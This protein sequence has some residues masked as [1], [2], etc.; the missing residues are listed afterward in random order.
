MANK[1]VKTEKNYKLFFLRGQWRFASTIAWGNISQIFAGI[2][3]HFAQNAHA[4][5]DTLEDLILH[6]RPAIIKW[7]CLS[8]KTRKHRHWEHQYVPCQKSYIPLIEWSCHRCGCP[9]PPILVFSNFHPCKPN[10]T[11]RSRTRKYYKFSW[12]P[13][14]VSQSQ[15]SGSL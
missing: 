11:A 10:Q 1:K 4:W 14:V 3:T 6:W 9:S 15:R 7:I 8:G 13:S 5:L 12:L 2:T